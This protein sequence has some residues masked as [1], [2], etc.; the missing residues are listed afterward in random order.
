MTKQTPL[1]RGRPSS[2]ERVFPGRIEADLT[3][4][5]RPEAE[6]HQSQLPSVF[7]TSIVSSGLIATIALGSGGWQ[8]VNDGYRISYHLDAVW[9]S[10]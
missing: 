6:A 5:S 8:T 3:G 4:C 10:R 7:T 1:S 9:T 2:D